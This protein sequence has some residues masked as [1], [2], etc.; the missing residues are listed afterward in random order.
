M[1]DYK[2]IGLVF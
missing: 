1:T 2:I